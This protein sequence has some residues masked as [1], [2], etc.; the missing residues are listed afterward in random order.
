MFYKTA[1]TET[2]DIETELKVA[3]VQ[4]LRGRTK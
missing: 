2:I 3:R 4:C 1:Q